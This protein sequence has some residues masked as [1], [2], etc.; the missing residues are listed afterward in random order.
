MEVKFVSFDR[1]FL[2]ASWRWLQDE[3]LRKLIAAAPITRENQERWFVQLPKRTDYVIWGIMSKSQPIGVCGI[4]QIVSGSGE[5][6]GYIGEKNYW[7]KGIGKQMLQFTEQA[8]KNIGL[9]TLT[10]QVAMH[11][12]RAV[13]LYLKYGYIINAELPGKYK[14]VK[15]LQHD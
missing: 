4:K 6:W 12:E 8:A 15:Q 10:L 9:T 7:G 2:E 14:M 13:K 1:V 5:Y 11:N 3:E